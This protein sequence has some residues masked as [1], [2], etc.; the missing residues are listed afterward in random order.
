MAG[1]EGKGNNNVGSSQGESASAERL[2]KPVKQ[3]SPQ[4]EDKSCD[5]KR[6]FAGTRLQHAAI[7]ALKRSKML[8]IYPLETIT[9]TSQIPYATTEIP[10]ITKMMSKTLKKL[11]DGFKSRTIPRKPV[12]E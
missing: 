2:E 9:N 1:T 11:R 8:A 10:A 5:S 12:N 6:Q 4:A 3:K 7:D